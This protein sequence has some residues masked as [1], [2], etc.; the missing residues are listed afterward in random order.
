[1]CRTPALIH[2]L[3]P[4]LEA[5][6]NCA[7][8][9]WHFALCQVYVYNAVVL[10]RQSIYVYSMNQSYISCEYHDSVHADY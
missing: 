2:D 5:A 3:L 9:Q 10:P 4:T 1:M 7:K 8:V 6:S